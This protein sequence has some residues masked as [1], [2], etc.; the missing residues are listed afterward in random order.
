[1]PRQVLFIRNDPTAPE[2]LLG[3]VFA[4]CGFEV[5]TFDVVT[6]DRAGDPSV[7]VT[8]PDPSGYDVSVPLG[9]RWAAYDDGLRAPPKLSFT[10]GHWGCSSTPEVDAALVQ[11]WIAED[12]DG[13]LGRLG[14]S[15][16]DL[17]ARTTLEVDDAARRLRLLVGGFLALLAEQ[18]TH[19]SDRIG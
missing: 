17:R 15:A 11:R 14:S 18:D 6:A 12:A 10:G 19:Q 1:M 5:N 13:D 4:E 16:Q 3:D 9:A 2:A 8:F 7:E